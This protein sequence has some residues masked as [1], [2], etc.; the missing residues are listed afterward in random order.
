M[1]YIIISWV[2]TIIEF[3]VQDLFLCWNYDRDRVCLFYDQ[4]QMW[5]FV[6]DCRTSNRIES[7]SS[8][9]Y[10]LEAPAPTSL[11][12]YLLL[13]IYIWISIFIYVCFKISWNIFPNLPSS[14]FSTSRWNSPLEN[15]TLVKD[16]MVLNE[17]E[18][19]TLIS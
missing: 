11:F 18:K 14:T 17:N 12:K 10:D 7:T 4:K 15:K 1:Y 19:K 8:F 2:K 3:F 9:W 5:D 16:K 13:N 6:V